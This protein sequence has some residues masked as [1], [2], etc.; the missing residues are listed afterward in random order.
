[1][2]IR[3]DILRDYNIKY[4]RSPYIV[5]IGDIIP[6]TNI[7]A[8]ITTGN[9]NRFSLHIP[10]ASPFLIPKYLKHSANRIN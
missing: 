8:Y 5:F 7:M 2:H 1:M 3:E 10:T 6:P 9:S 4:L